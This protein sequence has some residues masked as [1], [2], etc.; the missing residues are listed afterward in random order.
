MNPPLALSLWWQF[1]P[2]RLSR[3]V[4]EFETAINTDYDFKGVWDGVS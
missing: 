3:R 4:A 2:Q 1:F